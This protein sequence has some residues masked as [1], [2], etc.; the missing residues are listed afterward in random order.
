MTAEGDPLKTTARLCLVGV[1]GLALLACG[2][3][4][5]EGISLALE[6]GPSDLPA[7]TTFIRV[8]VLPGALSDNTKILCEDFVGPDA[9]KS[10][11]D[12]TLNVLRTS[13][14]DFN[15]LT[16]ATIML[17][18]LPIGLLVFYVEALDQGSNVLAYGCGMGQVNKGE[19]TYIPIRM[20]NN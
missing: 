11:Y 9:T 14:S 6:F 15:P 19:K 10:I 3:D 12:Y 18:G 2:G 4:G 8:Y 1:L 17:E 20:V 7:E 5:T 13:T 16:G